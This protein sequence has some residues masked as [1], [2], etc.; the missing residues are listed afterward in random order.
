MVIGHSSL[1]GHYFCLDLQEADNDML[2]NVQCTYMKCKK[3]C[4]KQDKKLTIMIFH[5]SSMLS[6]PIRE[7]PL[8][9]MP[10]L[11]GHC[12]NGGGGLD[13]CPNGLGH[14]F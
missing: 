7:A 12:P 13:P 10:G 9:K 11:F 14:L 8:R 5:M 4:K 6:V 3:Y 1:S 2:Y